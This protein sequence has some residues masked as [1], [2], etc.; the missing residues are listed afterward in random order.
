MCETC[1]LK[2]IKVI[3]SKDHL[4]TVIKTKSIQIQFIYK[5]KYCLNNILYLLY[6]Q[7]VTTLTWCKKDSVFY[8]D[9]LNTDLLNR[10]IIDC[11]MF[12]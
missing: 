11:H 2:V 4:Y 7:Y 12:V 1:I 8:I 5:G 3:E 6:N 10:N 9:Y